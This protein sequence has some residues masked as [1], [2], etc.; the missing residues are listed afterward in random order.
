MLSISSLNIYPVKSLAGISLNSAALTNQGLQF[1]R[2]WMVVDKRGHFV[3]QRELPAM[4]LIKTTLSADKLKL[5][6]PDLGSVEIALHNQGRKDCTVKVWQ[7]Y[8]QAYDQG[9]QAADFLAAALDLPLRLVRMKEDFRRPV[10]SKYALSVENIVG[11]AD[12]FPLLVI[13]DESLEELNEKLEYPL[14][15]NRFRPNITICG[16]EPFAEDNWEQLSIGA[17]NVRIALRKP[18]ARCPVTTVD[19]ETA[20]TSREPLRTLSF[21]RKQ[22]GKVMFGQNAVVIKIGTISCGDSVQVLA[23]E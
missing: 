15:M 8:C 16:G 4:A 10:D 2:Q 20:E 12:G 21:F 3:S 7:D 22:N 11:F 5:S 14:P 6:R 23:L 13:S 9:E 17:D 1:D 18:C 19:Q